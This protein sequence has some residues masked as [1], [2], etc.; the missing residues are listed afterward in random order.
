MG[1]ISADWWGKCIPDDVKKRCFEKRDAEKKKHDKMP[2]IKGAERKLLDYTDLG[3]LKEIIVYNFNW[4]KLFKK[5]FLREKEVVI[6]WFDILMP[7][8]NQIVHSS[9]PLDQNLETQFSAHAWKIITTLD[10]KSNQE[11]RNDRK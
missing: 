10:S 7:L 9:L 11:L 3:Q 4:D 6:E 2:F 5:I 8:R 1:K